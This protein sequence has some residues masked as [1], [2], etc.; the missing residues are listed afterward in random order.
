MQKTVEHARMNRVSPATVELLIHERSKG[1]S[2]RQLG[3]MFSRSHEG[4]R[5]IL[6]KYSPSRVTLL[7][8]HTVA[9]K[10]GYLPWWLIQLRKEGIVNPTKPGGRWFYT[11]EQVRQ[12]P[13]LVTEMRRCELCGEPRPP[14]SRKF[15]RECGQ[16]RRKHYYRSLS[17]EEKA[18]HRKKCVALRK[19]NPE[20]W[21]E[22]S[23]RA[24]RK[25]RARV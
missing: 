16:C 21:K 3:Q 24:H 6:A 8:E 17:P 12:I 18:D 9:V 20:K 19:A 22:I 23:S 14:G 4:V 13:L 25:S 7:P 11:E 5:Q 15:C 2:L 1:K 10:L